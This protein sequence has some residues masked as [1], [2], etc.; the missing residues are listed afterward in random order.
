M[1]EC[2]AD[3]GCLMVGM[4]WLAK[5]GYFPARVYHTETDTNCMNT[6]IYTYAAEWVLALSITVSV[7]VLNKVGRWPP[8]LDRRFKR[9]TGY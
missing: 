2:V 1:H 9:A 5:I 3:T 4:D 7:W 8:P 6:N